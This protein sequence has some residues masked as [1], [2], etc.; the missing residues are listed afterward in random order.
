[1]NSAMPCSFR[2]SSGSK[3]LT[4]R[5]FSTPLLSVNGST[6]LRLHSAPFTKS[7]QQTSL[8]MIVQTRSTAD[9]LSLVNLLRQSQ[10]DILETAGKSYIIWPEKEIAYQVYATNIPVER[11]LT[12]V[13]PLVNLSFGII[14]GL[15]NN[16]EASTVDNG[17][18]NDLLENWINQ[19][20]DEFNRD[21]NAAAG[22]IDGSSGFGVGGITWWLPK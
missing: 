20:D 1:M 3:Q 9:Y 11:Q 13:A 17:G 5:S 16:S 12:D 4:V 2:C 14:T 7:V 18:Y 10:K 19:T 15:V 6:Q 21:D 8:Q 22:N